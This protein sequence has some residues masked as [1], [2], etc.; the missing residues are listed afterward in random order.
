MAFGQW[1]NLNLNQ[2]VLSTFKAGDIEIA[3]TS[4]GIFYKNQNAATWTQASGITNKAISFDS[5]NNTIYASIYE[6]LY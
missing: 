6:N 5:Y 2:N 3:G 1:Q 4:T